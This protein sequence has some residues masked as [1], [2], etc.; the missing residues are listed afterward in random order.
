VNKQFRLLMLM[1]ALVT[2]GCAGTATQ[3]PGAPAGEK[4]LVTV[5]ILPQKYFVERIGGERVEVNVMVGPG[6]DPHTYEPKPD[7]M[8]ALAG[9]KMYFTIGVDFEKAW[10]DRFQ[11]ANPDLKF[12]DTTA[13]LQLVP[14]PE[15][16]YEGEK[17]AADGHLE[18]ELDT[19]TWTSP[20]M[21]KHQAEIISQSL[22]ALDAEN[23]DEYQK[24]YQTFTAEITTL[25]AEI[26]ETLQGVS[27][28]KFLVFHPAWGYFAQE[29]GLEQVAVEA[30]GQEPSAQ[31]LADIINLAKAE[32]IKVVFAQP[33]ISTR[34]AE[35][36][37]N[38]IGGKVLLISPLAEN[39]LENMAKVAQAFKDA[40]K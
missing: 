36:I 14:M 21:V 5:S 11:G 6:A 37:A 4:I 27:T 15:H 13:G 8:K 18:E 39:W 12:V 10:L 29:F 16:A 25:Q 28:N 40:L 7:Q 38:E 30:G 33:E 23:A 32:H 34:S 17:D 22:A 3:Q 1:V 20:Q 31:E 2:A 19:H 35:I 9:S 24:N 26:Q